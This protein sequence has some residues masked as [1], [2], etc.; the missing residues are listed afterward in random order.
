MNTIVAISTAPGNAG[1]GIIRLSGDES[2]DIIRKIFKTKDELVNIK[3]NTIRYGY[4]A[5]GDEIIDEV[6]VSFFK[7]PKSFTTEN[8]CEINSHGGIIIMQRILELCLENGA[9]LAEP[10]RVY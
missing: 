10:R 2:F 6:L 9:I 8:M 5:S 7:A 4:I 1:I 3:P